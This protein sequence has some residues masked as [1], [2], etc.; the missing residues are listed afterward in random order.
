MDTIK[1][2]II[3]TIEGNG[4]MFGGQL[5]RA[6]AMIHECKESNVERRMRELEDEGTLERRLVDN[7]KKGNKVVQY[8]IKPYQRIVVGKEYIEVPS[9]F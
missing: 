8:R 7:P 9:L 4:W 3:K 1:H 5:A 2:T 6:V